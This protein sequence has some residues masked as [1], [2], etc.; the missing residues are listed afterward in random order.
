MCIRDLPPIASLD[1]GGFLVSWYSDHNSSVYGQRFDATGNPT[2]MALVG[3]DKAAEATVTEAA[4]NLLVN[5]GDLTDR[6]TFR[7]HDDVA[8]LINVE[9]A[10]MGCGAD[11]VFRQGVHASDQVAVRPLGCSE[12][13]Y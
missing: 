9:P 12:S 6:L 10:H 5:L 1:D 4:D 2:I 8:T 7:D 3:T 13:N 11:P